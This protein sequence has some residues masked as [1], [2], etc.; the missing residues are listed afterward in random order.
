MKQP[1]LQCPKIKFHYTAETSVN[2]T[3][4]VLTNRLLLKA[5]WIRINAFT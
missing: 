2:M 4:L 5:C 3:R 1:L